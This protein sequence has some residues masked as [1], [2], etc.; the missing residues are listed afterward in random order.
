VGEKPTKELVLGV[1]PVGNKPVE[2]A[3]IQGPSVPGITKPSAAMKQQVLSTE[4]STPLDKSG[5]KFDAV[6]KP[7]PYKT[8]Q[9]E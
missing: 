1:K 7:L 3:T 9:K 5:I 4:M 2:P 8:G 6:S